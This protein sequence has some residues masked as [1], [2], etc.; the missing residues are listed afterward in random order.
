M[1]GII[2]LFILFVILFSVRIVVSRVFI[3]IALTVVRVLRIVVKCRRMIRPGPAIRQD[4]ERR[5]DLI[6][7]YYKMQELRK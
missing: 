2:V 7:M 5:K 3:L 1:V 4:I 6:D